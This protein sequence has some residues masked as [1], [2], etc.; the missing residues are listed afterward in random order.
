MSFKSE[1]LFRICVFCIFCG[2][3]NDRPSQFLSGNTNLTL[4]WRIVLSDIEFFDRAF[5]FLPFSTLSIILQP[6]GLL[7]LMRVVDL[8]GGYPCT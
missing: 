7:N 4:F 8:T 3:T 5:F 1:G 6:S 2:L